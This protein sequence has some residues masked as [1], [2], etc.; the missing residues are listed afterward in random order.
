MQAD[1]AG[2]PP[3]RGAQLWAGSAAVSVSRLRRSAV[4]VAAARLIEHGKPLA[5][6]QIELPTPSDDEVLVELAYAGVNPVD[7]YNALGSVAADGP[8]P[9]TL[10]AEASGH[11]DGVAVVVSGNGLGSTCDGVFAE[12]AVVPRSAVF[13]IPDGV[14]LRDAAAVGIVA[15][16]AFEA[17]EL[18]TVT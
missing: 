14:A 9:R 18:A 5:V 17:V 11:A 1:L 12:A 2:S 6:E 16:T 10:G 4:K 13:P 7:R 15:V 8:V 3:V